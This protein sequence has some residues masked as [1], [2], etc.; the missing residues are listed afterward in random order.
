MT[1]KRQRVT[2]KTQLMDQGLPPIYDK[3]FIN[4]QWIAAQSG[5]CFTVRNP[6]NGETLADVP[7]M[8]AADITR[9]I[10]AAAQSTNVWRGMLPAERAKILSRWAGLIEERA[11]D[12]ALLMTL[13]QGKPLAEARGEVMA[14]AATVQ[15]CAEE[16][17]RLYGEYLEGPKAGTRI[18]V[19]RHPVGVV[20]AITPWNFPV[21]MIT[22]K[23][24]PALAAGCTVILK[25]AESTPLCAL[26]L[27]AL[28]E[29][30]GLP[31][32]VFNVVT[33]AN[34]RGAGE[35][36]TKDARVRK[37]SFTG[38]TPV[39]KLLMAQAA[40]NLQ[41][42]SLELGGNAP[43][44]VT[45]NANLERAAD[46]A[47]ASKFRNAGQTCICANRIFVHKNVY[48][49]FKEIFLRK[50]SELKVG[51]GREDGVTIGPLIDGNALQ[52]VERLVQSA[53]SEGAVILTG[54]KRHEL[55]GS[56]YEP[57]LI[58]GAGDD[59]GIFREE[60]FGP[61]AVLYIYDTADEVVL[62]ANDTAFGLAA[63][64]YSES[65]KE[66]WDLSD[67]LAY[68]MVAINEPM[69]ATDLAPFGGVKE[70]GIGREG[71]KYGLLEYTE[72]K[73]RLLG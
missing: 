30:A 4:G 23:V 65:L 48:D 62:R 41:K 16:G 20:A 49:R 8:D 39:G 70:S 59:A 46:G 11:D 31:A 72:I 33:T 42:V 51:D 73:Y 37:I 2:D 68:G 45:A 57:T 21:G 19:S 24:G 40:G 17:R 64:V 7:D 10:D 14:A 53:R 32:G 38:S 27:A 44:I 34:A 5:K 63:Y 28:A 26:S 36:M 61:V 9:A 6:A 55:G 69:L 22:R 1:G 13:E 60:I 52:K 3:A 47:I 15:W 56:F 29:K 66:V 25:P 35:V 71:G 18:L 12:L 43:F 54:G 67:R 50:I 58:E